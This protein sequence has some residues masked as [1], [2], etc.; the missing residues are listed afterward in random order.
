MTRQ[1][2][3]LDDIFNLRNIIQ[4]IDLISFIIANVGIYF[5]VDAFIE[6]D[7]RIFFIILFLNLILI[8]LDLIIFLINGLNNIISYLFSIDIKIKPYLILNLI[9]KIPF[10]ILEIVKLPIHIF[11]ILKRAYDTFHINIIMLFPFLLLRIVF[12]NSMQ[13][14]LFTLVVW[15]FS[16]SLF[17]K[18]DYVYIQMNEISSNFY[19]SIGLVGILAGFFQYYIKR[20]EDKVQAKLA[21]KMNGLI[22]I[23]DK[24]TSFNNFLTF[25][26]T[27]TIFKNLRTGINDFIKRDQHSFQ[28]LGYH[29]DRSGVKEVNIYPLLMPS[30][31]KGGYILYENE[32]AT[33]DDKIS[34]LLNAY[35]DFFM[36]KKDEIID[37]ILQKRE[38]TDLIEMLLLNINFITEIKSQII[39]IKM[40]DI[41]KLKTADE[42]IGTIK[43]EIID[44]LISKYIYKQHS[45]SKQKTLE[46]MFK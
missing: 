16:L 40:E 32:I 37:E 2:F 7:L 42:F 19:S 12:F 6:I 24:Y 44:E 8:K 17:I 1:D 21:I 29:V 11:K 25:L 39:G 23:T 14:L 33:K 31:E 4:F 27:K 3:L 13:Y 41:D 10:I 18:L 43:L 28:M 15:I 45:T 38:I 26:K 22:S 5:L 35:T 46:N 34:E 30:S 9:K 36:M 20:H